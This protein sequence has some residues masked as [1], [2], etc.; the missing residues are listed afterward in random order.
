MTRLDDFSKKNI[1]SVFFIASF[2]HLQTFEE[3]VMTLQNLKKILVPNSY[4]F[5]TNWALD[6]EVNREKYEKN[7]LPNSQNKWG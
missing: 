7:I 5:L 6:S 1:E 2:H 4:V 3:R